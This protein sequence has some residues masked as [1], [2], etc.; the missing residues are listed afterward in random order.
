MFFTFYKRSNVHKLKRE[1]KDE[2]IALKLF[3]RSKK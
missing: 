2:M 1:S 3:G